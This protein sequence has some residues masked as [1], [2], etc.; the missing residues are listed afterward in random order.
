MSEE[1]KDD[2]LSRGTGSFVVHGK[3]ASV[4]TFGSEFNSMSPDERLRLRRQSQ[5]GEVDGLSP[6]TIEDDFHSVLAE[7]IEYHER[8]GSAAT[9]STATARSFRELHKRLGH[10]DSA[11][12]DGDDS[13]AV[14]FSDGRRTPLPR[15]DD[16]EDDHVENRTSQAMYFTPETSNTP[17]TATFP[18]EVNSKDAEEAADETDEN[19]VNDIHSTTHVRATVRV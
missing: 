17:I 4:I 6:V 1:S 3:K 12:S 5:K 10:S 13:D 9:A 15:V 18:D 2:V 7:P 11:A 16:E 19:A 8:H 14:S